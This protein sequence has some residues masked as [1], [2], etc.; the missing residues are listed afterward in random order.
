MTIILII[1]VF[2]YGI[3]IGS[4]LNVCIYRLPAGQSVILTRSHCTK[5]E[6]D[7]RFYDLIPIISYIFLNGKCRFCSEKISIRYPIIELL[8][9][10]LYIIAFLKFGISAETILY[11]LLS[12]VLLVIVIIDYEHQIIPNELV[13]VTIAIG[14]FYNILKGEIVHQIIG[15]FAASSILYLIAIISKG[16]IGG[17]DIKMVAAFGFCIGWQ[18]ILLSLF[19][20]SLVGSV[21]AIYLM[22]YKNYNRKTAVPFGPFIAIGIYISIMYGTDLINWYLKVFNI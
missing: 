1:I 19:L 15:F 7:I 16:G 2:L 8:N 12:S 11:C 10:I 6:K 21:V 20:G 18:K 9:G 13:I 5:C 14:I 4:F 22:F 3:T 17:G